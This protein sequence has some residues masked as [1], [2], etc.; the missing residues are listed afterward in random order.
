MASSGSSSNG[1]SGSGLRR[2][3]AALRR[4][5][6]DQTD[7]EA[8]VP[9]APAP[10]DAPAAPGALPGPEDRTQ[11]V[12][13]SAVQATPGRVGFKLL[14]LAGPRAGA[15]FE[16][17]TDEAT[18]GRGADNQISVPD[19]SVSRRHVKFERHGDT[20]I[21]SDLG[22]GN[23]TKVND[24]RVT[25]AEV[26]HG[27]EIAIGDTVVQLIEVGAPAVKKGRRS[28]SPP[29]GREAGPAAATGTQ[30]PRVVVGAPV[31]GAMPPE[32]RRLYLV[33]AG[34]L[35]LLLLVGVV[36]QLRPAG[37]PVDDGSGV[38]GFSL[39]MDEAR[40]LA[41][42]HD[43]RGAARK[44]EEALELAD[45]AKAEAFL[46]FAKTEAGHQAALEL[47]RKAL[48][49]G[50]FAAARL[51]AAGIPPEADVYPQAREL[52]RDVPG[53]LARAYEDAKQ[54]FDAGDRDGARAIVERILAAD[55]TSAGALALREQL[56]KRVI[57]PVVA[58][59]KVVTVSPAPERKA[60]S[61]PSGPAVSFFLAGDLPKAL[62]AA[63][64]SN[65][66]G[67]A[68]L[69]KQ[70]RAFD[71]NYREGIAKAQAQ[72][73]AEAIKPLG[74]ALQIARDV[75]RGRPSKPGEVVARQLA[76][77]EYLLGIDCKGDEQ[78][79]RAAAHYRAALEA[80]PDHV[81]SKKQI[82]RVEAR[83][84]EMYQE[85]YVG[86]SNSPELSLKLFKIARDALPASDEYKEKAN[87]WYEKLQGTVRN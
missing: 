75:A 25:S 58:E 80:D 26:R 19:V 87:N 54:R 4:H 12:A 66:G 53:A 14:C 59:R 81:L 78:L 55:A 47:A 32:R 20:W 49:E 33:V 72:R 77:M 29:S 2:G 17:R 44:A 8:L 48:R 50:D 16:L 43:W 86:K 37:E 27:D 64:E 51:G 35:G 9:G 28:P 41:R 21:V 13:A 83:A 5:D 1:S 7:P 18:I 40:D 63:E 23:G 15:E 85:A 45:D 24:S 10:V 73:A 56:E 6:P 65:D 61:M 67:A 42:K 3:G 68:K 30:Q 60:P 76:N 31:A 22:S 57:R 34:L 62:R 39:V 84:R 70:L 69:L 36:K 52:V 74:T 71:A 38:D 11:V 82:A 46:R 79:A